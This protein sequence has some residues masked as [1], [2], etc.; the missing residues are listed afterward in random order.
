MKGGMDGVRG[1]DGPIMN[2]NIHSMIVRGS[3]SRHRAMERPYIHRK[4]KSCPLVNLELKSSI[5]CFQ[6]L[7]LTIFRTSPSLSK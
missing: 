6:S 4:D 3:V 2:R 7:L 5:A 1:A